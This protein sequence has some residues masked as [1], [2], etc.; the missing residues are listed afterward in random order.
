MKA[1]GEHLVDGD[2]VVHHL[3]GDDGVEGD[4]PRAV[5]RSHRPG[6]DERL[7]REFPT[8]GPAE[9]RISHLISGSCPTP[10]GVTPATRPRQWRGPVRPPFRGFCPLRTTM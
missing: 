8:E 6:P 1:F 3:D 5:D 4:V 10:L 9:E 7:E 2:V